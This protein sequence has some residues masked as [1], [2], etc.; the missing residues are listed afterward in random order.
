VGAGLALSRIELAVS[1]KQ[2]E[3][4][5]ARW[6]AR[7]KFEEPD[8]VPVMLGIAT[9]Y[10]L[11]KFG[12]TFQEYFSSPQVMLEAQAKSIEWIFA[13]ARD[14]R[15]GIAVGPDFQNV[16]EA[17]G[18]GCAIKYV[19]GF[20]WVEKP[21][22]AN[23]GDLGRLEATDMYSNGFTGRIPQYRREMVK[24]TQGIS[25]S[26]K[27]G[28]SAP[29]IVGSGMG[30]DGP[31]T[32]CA[33][34][35]GSTQLLADVTLKPKFVHAMMEIVT[36]K[37]IEFNQRLREDAEIPEDCGM[38]VADD[39]AAFLS[40][41]Q[42]RE[43]ALP[44]HERIYD[45]FRTK[46][47]DIHLCGKIDHLLTLLVNE[48]RIHSLSGFGWVTDA[49]RVA[50][51]MGGKVLLYGGPNPSLILSGPKSEIIEAAKFYI[52]L[53]GPYR[54]YALGDGYN[55]APGTPVNHMNALMDAATQYGQYPMNK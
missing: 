26:F 43:F 52:Q 35:R 33:W 47:R 20:P 9:R 54:G 27:G 15:F 48:Q 18:L 7:D 28:G 29:L 39:F 38:G 40:P 55:I 24:L 21:I 11:P 25:V 2:L 12:L 4:R 23:Q 36:D 49:L 44:Y 45:A 13:N 50:K 10:W 41:D 22:I 8:R 3:E 37:I 53:L 16:R 34:L 6:Q 31:F 51:V 14:D 19:E 5:K 32:N 17:S 1:A 30:T 42:Y 46:L